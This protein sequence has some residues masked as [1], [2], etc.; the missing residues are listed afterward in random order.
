MAA[1]LKTE[2]AVPRWFVEF[3]SMKNTTKKQ[4]GN[5][6]ACNIDLSFCMQNMGGRNLEIGRA[7]SILAK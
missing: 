4:V 5:L 2:P 7:V 3:A 1:I 6:P